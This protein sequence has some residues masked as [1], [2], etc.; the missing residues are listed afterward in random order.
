M[1]L[2]LSSPKEWQPPVPSYREPYSESNFYAEFDSDAEICYESRGVLFRFTAGA[3]RAEAGVSKAGEPGPKSKAES[4]AIQMEDPIV[5]SAVDVGETCD[6]I[7]DEQHPEVANIAATPFDVGSDRRV[8][9]PSSVD[10]GLRLN[11]PSGS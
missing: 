9:A 1:T 4:V 8:D 5:E 11:A 2:L 7:V 10:S 6:V 3:M